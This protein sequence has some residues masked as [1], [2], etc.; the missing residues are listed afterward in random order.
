M[1]VA[2]DIMTWSSALALLL[3][4]IL[5]KNSATM[6]HAEE[7]DLYKKQTDGFDKMMRALVMAIINKMMGKI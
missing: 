2:N 4:T 3:C 6:R 7:S 1:A 5:E